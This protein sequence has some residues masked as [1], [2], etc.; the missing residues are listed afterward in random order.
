MGF[1]QAQANIEGALLEYVFYYL[2]PRAL[3]GLRIKEKGVLGRRQS[4]QS[5]ILLSMHLE[6]LL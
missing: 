3:G 4:T 6:N 2:L 1:K 5:T